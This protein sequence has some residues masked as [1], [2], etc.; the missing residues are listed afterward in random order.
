[1]L[2]FFAHVKID[3]GG[4]IDGNLQVF[5]SILEVSGSVSGDIQAYGS[6]V[7]VDTP[8]AQVDGTINTFGSMRDLPNFPSILLV[9]S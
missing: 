6:Q 5:G 3:E 2:L 1:M 8:E 9:I 7:H 4:Q